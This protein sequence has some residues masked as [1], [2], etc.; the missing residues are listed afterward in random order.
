MKVVT[1][2][3]KRVEQMSV[4]NGLITTNTLVNSTL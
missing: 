3:R 4:A 1:I 2:G